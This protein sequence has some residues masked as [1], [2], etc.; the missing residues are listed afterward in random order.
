MCRT[1]AKGDQ[2][3]YTEKEVTVAELKE[4]YQSDDYEIE[5]STPD[6]YQKITN[7]FD[8]GSLSMV[9]VVT[10]EFNTTCAVNHMLQRTDGLWLAAD[11]LTP[12]ESVLTE[13]GHQKI[14]S[15]VATDTEECYDFTVDHPNHR[16]WGDG[17]SSHNSGKS[18]LA[19]GNI[20]KNAQA[21]GIF[22]I[23]IDS[24][25][26]LDKSWL[27]A[28]GV[29]TGEDKLL[30]LNMAMIDDVA[31]T[32]NNF[33]KEYRDAYGSA[34]DEDRP[35][36]LFVIDSLG[37]LM[38]PTEVNQFEA[39]DMKGDMG[40]KAKALKALVTNCVNMFGDLDIGLVA[41]QHTYASQNMF[42]PDPVIAGGC[43]TA[44]HKIML[45]S[46]TAKN[47]ED[48]VVGDV[49]RTLN[50]DVEVAKTFTFT[51]KEVFE[52]ELQDG[53]ILQAT[54]E[55]KFLVQL[56]DSTTVWKTVNELS[57]DDSILSVV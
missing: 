53:T 41:T 35:K 52:L 38:S 36:V 29:D 10:D 18:F 34:A 51:D 17:F 45:A 16:Y 15:I 57:Q 9:K 27:E 14:I 2:M 56:A 49:V 50:D 8:K 19:S 55:H 40:R 26:A 13:N 54:G 22:I 6:G 11:E 39:G 12:G 31:K 25:N 46:G 28:L 47:I 20:V 43:L 32:I 30:K 3:Q 23:L 4:L 42:S 24:E 21:Q 33:V 44:G 37:M 7:W 48:I 5:I 1:G